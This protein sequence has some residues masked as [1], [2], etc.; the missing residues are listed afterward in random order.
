MAFFCYVT[1]AA[2]W[3]TVLTT[4]VAAQP[5]Q[6]SVRYSLYSVVKS[7]DEPAGQ[8]QCATDSPSATVTAGSLRCATECR[9]RLLCLDFNVVDNDVCQLFDFTPTSY[10]PL[11]GCTSFHVDES[12]PAHSVLT[13]DADNTI[14]DLYIDGV[15]VNHLPGYAN[16]VVV[17]SVALK[18]WTR[19]IAVRA[20]NVLTASPAGLMASD[21]LG[22]VRTNAATWKCHN[23]LVEGWN[24]PDFDD[25]TW[26]AAA[27]IKRNDDPSGL[28]YGT[29]PTTMIHPHAWWIWTWYNYG[30]WSTDPVVYCRVRL[31]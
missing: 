5:L 9:E 15:R 3:L 1:C 31:Q 17:D 2:W 6:S 21:S 25:S 20:S 26:P 23:A 8:V 13:I 16:W 11:P 27:Q 10:A 29:Q 24:S 4:N 14:E 28:W 12:T 7:P 22:R 19:V 18:S 30:T